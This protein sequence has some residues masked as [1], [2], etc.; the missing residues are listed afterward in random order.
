[1]FIPRPRRNDIRKVIVMIKAKK[2]RMLLFFIAWTV[3]FT[4][5]ASASPSELEY[6][7]A[8]VIWR[9]GDTRVWRFPMTSAVEVT[10]MS[11]KFNK[12]YGGGFKL[13]DLNV[14]KV[15]DKWSLCVKDQVLFTAHPDHS[16]A[17]K[18]NTRIIALQWMSRVYE[19]VG[20][21]HAQELTPEYEL[22]G[23]FEVAT[24]VSWYGDKFIGRK[25][26]NG[27]KFTDS[28]LTAAA[29]NLPFDTLVM[30]TTP[31]TGRSV[32]VRITDRFKEHKNRAL[33][34]SHAAAEVLGIRGMGVVK[35][36]IKVIGRV[37]LIG[38]K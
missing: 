18:L 38:G 1:M 24:S 15:D 7:G 33:D 32:V 27:E 31:A 12:L 22:R 23:G 9:V 26:A 28:H 36:Q 25:F 8:T 30:V 3:I 34:I 11:D 21:M 2:N 14:A 6:E 16:V 35:A 19:A 13:V 4:G 20:A 10:T 17:L 5:T 37:G 29:K